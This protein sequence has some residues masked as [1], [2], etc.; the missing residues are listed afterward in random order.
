MFFK[1]VIFNLYF[2]IISH[3]MFQSGIILKRLSLCF[4]QYYIFSKSSWYILYFKK[5][6]ALLDTRRKYK[7]R[8]NMWQLILIAVAQWAN[9]W[10]EKAQRFREVA[11]FRSS[12]L[13]KILM[14]CFIFIR[15]LVFLIFLAM[16]SFFEKFAI[17][18]LRYCEL[19][20]ISRSKRFTNDWNR[21][22]KI[23]Q[24]LAIF[25]E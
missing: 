12:G 5:W 21:L 14:S 23:L 7:N 8:T 18:N 16:I 25:L 24:N 20:K 15:K 19:Y 11:H 6:F 3:N 1:I 10:R 17:R 2:F 4:G 9:I 22:D 13:G